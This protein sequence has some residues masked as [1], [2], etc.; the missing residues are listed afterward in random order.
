MSCHTCY[1]HETPGTVN[2]CYGNKFWTSEQLDDLSLGPASELG[3]DWE[4]DVT[5]VPV[6]CLINLGND[7][8][9]FSGICEEGE[10]VAPLI[11]GYIGLVSE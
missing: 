7:R 3:H 4:L 2:V 8:D 11:V 6:Y 1:S 5:C 9:L 10:Q